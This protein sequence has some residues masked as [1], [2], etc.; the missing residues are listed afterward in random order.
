MNKPT[1]I[2]VSFYSYPYTGISALRISFIANYLAK[3]DYK[4]YFIKADNSYY[5]QLIDPELKLEDNIQQ[6]SIFVGKKK[7]NGLFRINFIL[8][9]KSAIKK[10]IKKDKVDFIYFCSDPF[11]YLPLGPILKIFNKINFIIDFRDIMYRHPYFELSKYKDIGNEISDKLL[12][13]ICIKYSDLVIDV[14]EENTIIHKKIYS[15]YPSEKFITISNG[16]DPDIDIIKKTELFVDNENNE[17]N[18]ITKNI[19][20]KNEIN[21]LRSKE[22]TLSEKKINNKILL[23]ISGKFAYYNTEN[24]DWFLQLEEKNPDLCRKIEIIAIGKDNPIF[25]E[26]AKQSKIIKFIFYPQVSQKKSFEI[27][28]SSDILLLNNNQKTA[29]GTKIYDYI[30]LNKPI[31][32]FVKNDFAIAKLLYKFENAFIIENIEDLENALLKILNKNIFYL[33]QRKDLIKQYSR[34]YQ[35]EKLVVK[36]DELYKNHKKD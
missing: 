13:R 31:F 8:S 2:I 34:E 30:Y 21:K 16:Y 25:Q 3:K 10:I 5:N 35:C 26:K 11:W 17:N 33:T 28:K 24:I 22:N 15:K 19:E 12:E 32:A 20:F 7:N 14:T 9:I 36:I 4:I 18:I 6:I 1:L 29:L 27:L 23:A